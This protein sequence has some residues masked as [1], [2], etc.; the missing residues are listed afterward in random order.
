MCDW[1]ARRTPALHQFGGPSIH[2]YRLARPNIQLGENGRPLR[3][4]DYNTQEGS[5]QCVT[6]WQVMACS[7][8]V[9]YKHPVL[10]QQPRHTRPLRS[11]T[12]IHYPLFIALGRSGRSGPPLCGGTPP[13]TPPFSHATV[14]ARP[15]LVCQRPGDDSTVRARPQLT[16]QQAGSNATMCARFQLVVNAPSIPPFEFRVSAVSDHYPLFTIH[17][18]L[19]FRNP[20][21][22]SPPVPR[23]RQLATGYRPLAAGH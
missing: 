12:P 10:R 21:P 6:N 2:R 23:H 9:E 18:P 15:Q 16:R 20:L 11:L 17:Y 8:D 4:R 14:L 13:A 3:L 1:I 7:P 22:P 19:Q 5:D